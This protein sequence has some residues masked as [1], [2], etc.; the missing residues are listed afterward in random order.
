VV[1]TAVLLNLVLWW[2]W[3]W[4]WS[5]SWWLVVMVVVVPSFIRAEGQFH[6]TCRACSGE[7]S[8]CTCQMVMCHLS[9]R[10]SCI[11]LNHAEVCLC[12]HTWDICLS[13]ECLLRHILQRSQSSLFPDTWG[14][15]HYPPRSALFAARTSF[16]QALCIVCQGRKWGV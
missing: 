1:L 15:A 10:K 7:K 3:W 14:K 2:W 9:H 5:C 11:R 16:L 8:Y 13:Y 4:W 6:H 12:P